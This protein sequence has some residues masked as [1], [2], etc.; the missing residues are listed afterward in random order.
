MVNPLALRPARFPCLTS[1]AKWPIRT[2]GRR[3]VFRDDGRA[4]AERGTQVHRSFLAAVA[5]T[6]LFFTALPSTAAPT[7]TRVSVSNSERPGDDGSF[8]PNISP[9]G[10]FVAFESLANNLDPDDQTDNNLEIFLR[11]R[12]QGTTTL[13]S[14]SS[15]ESEGNGGSDDAVVS[16]DGKMVAFESEAGNLAPKDNSLPDDPDD[17]FVRNLSTGKTKLVSIGFGNVQP[18]EE[19]SDPTISADGRL[20]AF[21]SL[22]SNLTSEPDTNDESDIF[23]RNL[24]TGVTTRVSESTAGAQADFDSDA[25][26]MAGDGS[27]VAFESEATTLDGVEPGSEEDTDVFIKELATDQLTRVSVNDLGQQGDFFSFDPFVSATGRYVGFSSFAT[28]FSANDPNGVVDVFLRD[29]DEE[30]VYLISLN[31][32]EQNPATHDS[33]DAAVSKSGRYV[34][35]SSVA[36]FVGADGNG[37]G[38]VFLR[39]RAAGTTKRVSVAANGDEGKKASDDPLITPDGAF[40]A[41]DS[42]AQNLTSPTETVLRTSSCGAP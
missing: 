40:V 42:F 10:R 8:D 17:V 28:N 14:V 31:S 34:A 16:A 2:I 27:A 37:V 26:Y 20:I 19:S 6:G 9:N 1:Q 23:V 13:V 39:D 30:K 35:F 18:D 7:T 11:D 3:A 36:A 25:P 21:R 29:R 5:A 15:N 38:D 33:I 32:A 4:A 24:Q 12:Q 41:F 22:A